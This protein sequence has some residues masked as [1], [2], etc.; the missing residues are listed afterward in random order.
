M[1]LYR[2]PDDLSADL[3]VRGD[4]LSALSAPAP[5]RSP[6]FTSA[7]LPLSMLITAISVGSTPFFSAQ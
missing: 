7:S 3:V 4:Q 2:S 1:H 6:Y 5:L